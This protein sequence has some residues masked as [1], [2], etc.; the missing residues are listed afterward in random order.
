[1]FFG[2]VLDAKVH[3]LLTMHEDLFAAFFV[4]EA[5]FVEALAAFAA[6][7]LDGRHGG[8]V[9]ES[10]GWLGGAIVHS[11]GDNGA[12]GIAVEEFDDDFLADARDENR[13]PVFAGPAL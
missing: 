9:R 1:P 8:V 4:F 2:I 7:G 11:A 10:V 13:T 6:V 5:E 3:I 12:I